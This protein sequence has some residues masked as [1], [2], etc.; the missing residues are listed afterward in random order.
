VSAI[1]SPDAL[2]ASLEAIGDERYHD[3]HPFH[4]RLH[5]GRCTRAQ[6]QAWA[7]NRYYYQSRIP[8]KD[9]VILSRI[10]D[11]ALRRAWRQRILDHD[12]DGATDRGGI[13]KWL[14]LAEGLGLDREQVVATRG[15]LPGT[16][17]AV[18]AYLALVRERS[19]LEA[20]AS[21][22]TEL[23]SP[24]VIRTRVSG[25]LAHYDFVT[26]E[27]LAYFTARPEQAGR[28][29]A[30]A[31]GYVRAHATTP[32]TQA[33]V[34]AALRAKCDILWAMLDA[35][36]HAYVTPGRVPPGAWVPA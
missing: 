25:M 13:E 1:L 35:L 7:L 26:P 19:L 29:V 28:D 4:A 20:I 36:E 27:I 9:A 34:Q 3:R 21:S 14:V 5:E 15:I 11:P 23:F 31:L 24:K 33:A 16:R 30:V 32:E 18:D 6:V 22:L 12:G 2:V 17:Y 8:Q 10:E